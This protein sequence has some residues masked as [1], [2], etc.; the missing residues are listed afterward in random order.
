MS[1]FSDGG[2]SYH[3]PSFAVNAC[4]NTLG[5]RIELG[6]AGEKH[7]IVQPHSR[8]CGQIAVGGETVAPLRCAVS[9]CAVIVDAI[10][11]IIL[12]TLVRT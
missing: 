1:G 6:G 8:N 10:Y 11:P 4:H 3:A 5:S 2:L 7:R 12:V 9:V